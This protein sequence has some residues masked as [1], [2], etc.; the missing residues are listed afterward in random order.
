MPKSTSIHSSFGAYLLAG[1]CA[2]APVD[3]YA[4]SNDCMAK[5]A[6]IASNRVAP[7]TPKWSFKFRV[8]TKCAASTGRFQYTYRVKGSSTK[9]TERSVASWN[10]SNGAQFEW[11]DE[12]S[13]ADNVELEFFRVIEKSIEST[14][15]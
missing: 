12:V 6:P 15:L 13:A 14:K 2:V 5:V 7:D 4:T 1:I 10:A 3:A 9:P 8:T 11:S